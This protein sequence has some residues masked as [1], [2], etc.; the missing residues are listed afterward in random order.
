M[1]LIRVDLYSD[2]RCITDFLIF[3]YSQGGG[4]GGLASY[5]GGMCDFPLV[6]RILTHL[7][8]HL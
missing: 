7:L 6:Y 3:E 2:Q 4:F 8:F 5:G 1:Q